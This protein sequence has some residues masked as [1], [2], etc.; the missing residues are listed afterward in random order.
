M[1]NTIEYATMEDKSGVLKIWK[2]KENAKN[3][4]I[5]FNAKVDKYLNEKRMFCIKND[6]EII[7]FGGFSIMKRNPEIRIEHLCV[8]KKYRNQHL[9]VSIMKR[10]VDEVK[11]INLPLII[12]C[13]DGGGK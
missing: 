10:I 4:S 11:D 13:R 8:D 9:A 5:P 6:G 3:L 7:A 2:D 12:T 1:K